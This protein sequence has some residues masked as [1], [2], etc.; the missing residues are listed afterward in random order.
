MMVGFCHRTL[1][2]PSKHE[3]QMDSWNYSSNQNKIIRAFVKLERFSRSDPLFV[4]ENVGGCAYA[5][6]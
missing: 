2:T 5:L 4:I 3:N 1:T 6:G